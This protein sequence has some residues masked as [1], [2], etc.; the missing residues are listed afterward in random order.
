MEVF[1]YQHRRLQLT[2][3]LSLSALC[4]DYYQFLTIT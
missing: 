2:K 1:I 4:H 3:K